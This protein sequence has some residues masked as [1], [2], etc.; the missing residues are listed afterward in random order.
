MVQDLLGKLEDVTPRHAYGRVA[1]IQGH[2]VEVAGPLFEMSVGSMLAIHA[3]GKE[4]VMCEVVGF[5]Q[6]RA[7]CLPY[8]ELEGIRL[9]C[10]AVLHGPR[11]YSPDQRVAW[12]YGECFRGTDRWQGAIAQGA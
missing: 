5:S 9:G 1:S 7:L 12:S 8:G 2:L 4:P 11:C 3:Q 6:D 10:R